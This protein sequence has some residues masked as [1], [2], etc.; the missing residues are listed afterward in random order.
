[1][2][3]PNF[4]SSQAN[5]GGSLGGPLGALAGLALGPAGALAGAFGG[6]LL[7][8]VL[9]GLFTPG[10]N[11]MAKTTGFANAA[12]GSGIPAE[13]LLGQ[14]IQKYFGGTNTPLSTGHP[15][16]TQQPSAMANIL[17]FLTQTQLPGGGTLTPPGQTGYKNPAS[18]GGIENLNKLDQ[19]VPNFTPLSLNQ[20]KQIFPEIEQV[21]FH[22]QYGKGGGLQ[23]LLEG[24]NQ[25][26]TKLVNAE[27]Y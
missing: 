9:G 6:D 13:Q 8:S 15:N 7:G 10:L 1:L 20:L 19:M 25:L 18:I 22:R 21:L 17:E 27:S 4:N 11:R 2:F 16:V 3:G 14:Y 26:A 12:E 5:L 24:E 23:N